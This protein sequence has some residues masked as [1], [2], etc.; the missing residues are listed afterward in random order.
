MAYIRSI[1][2]DRIDYSFRIE[3]SAFTH[4]T[5]AGNLLITGLPYTVNSSAYGRCQGGLTF[6][7]ITKAGYTQFT[8]EPAPG[9]T[10]INIFACG[11]GVAVAATLI[12]DLP[13]GGAVTLRGAGHYFL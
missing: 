12:T 9:T 2:G 4:T 7:G 1:E 3:T 11:S 6:S 13:T 8:P 5:A 10:N